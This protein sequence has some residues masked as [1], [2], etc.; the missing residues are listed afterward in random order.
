MNFITGA[1][2]EKLKAKTIGV[3]PEHLSSR[4]A[5]TDISGTV[6]YTEVLGSDS[7]LYVDNAS[8]H[9]H[10]APARHEPNSRPDKN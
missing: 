2:A 6:D 7:F 9:A 4:T 10:R 8:R 3:R 1:P 5:K